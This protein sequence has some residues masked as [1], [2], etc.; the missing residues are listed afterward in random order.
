MTT[1]EPDIHA[2]IHTTAGKL[3]DLRR[4]TEETLHPV[5]ETAVE[6]VHAIQFGREVRVLVEN[7]RLNDQDAE[8]LARDIARKIETDLTYPGEVRVTVIR[9]TRAVQYAR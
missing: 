5:G 1:T 3:A 4:R 8:L 9:E 7:A 2:D 6:K